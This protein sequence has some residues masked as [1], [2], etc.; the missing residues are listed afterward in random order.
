MGTHGCAVETRAVE[1]AIAGFSTPHLTALTTFYDV[2]P[3]SK[4]SK[5]SYFSSICVSFY[6]LRKHFFKLWSTSSIVKRMHRCVDINPMTIKS[7]LGSPSVMAPRDRKRESSWGGTIIVVEERDPMFLPATDS[8]TA[9]VD[10]LSSSNWKKRPDSGCHPHDTQAGPCVR[11]LNI[12]A[13]TFVR[14]SENLI[15]FTIHRI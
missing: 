2:A 15:C 1:A 6:M 7:L 4:P 10:S 3:L 12:P 13:Q 5:L 9:V 8:E 14:L 11:F